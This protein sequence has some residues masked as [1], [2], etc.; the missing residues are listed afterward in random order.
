MKIQTNCAFSVP[1]EAFAVSAP[2]A[3]YTLQYSA[4]GNTFTDYE[5][6]IPANEVLFVSGLPKNCIYKLNS[7]VD[8]DL[9]IQY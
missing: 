7:S 8:E 3:S 4:D 1:A 9:Y 2:S 5:D 6:E